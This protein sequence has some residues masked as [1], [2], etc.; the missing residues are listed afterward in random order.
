MP[1][2]TFYSGLI[3]AS[4]LSIVIPLSFGA[5]RFKALSF[6]LRVLF[7]YVLICALTEGVSFLTAQ[8]HAEVFHFIQHLFTLIECEAF[9]LIF[10]IEFNGVAIR[11]FIVLASAIYFILFI[12]VLFDLSPYVPNNITTTIS[13]CLMI[14]LSFT[15]YYKRLADT[16][17]GKMTKSPAFWIATGVLLYFMTAFVLFLFSEQLANKENPAPFYF[18]YSLQRVVNILYN[19]MLG[20]ALWKSREK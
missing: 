1:L 7:F 8:G 14:F 18:F 9:L 20:I 11:R 2:I 5:A 17:P 3:Y 15:F 12:F 13:A 19:F 16:K 4:M 6:Q 10:F